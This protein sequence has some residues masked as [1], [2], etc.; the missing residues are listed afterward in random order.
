MTKHVD[1][2]LEYTG[3]YLQPVEYAVITPDSDPAHPQVPR[4]PPPKLLSAVCELIYFAK[5]SIAEAWEMPIGQADWYRGA[6]LKI[7]GNDVDFMDEDERE[8]Q[9]QLEQ[10][11]RESE[12]KKT[13]AEGRKNGGV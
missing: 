4:T 5:C 13:A 7:L 6:A 11:Q 1:R 9:R 8:F 10:A 3:D 12:A 2:F